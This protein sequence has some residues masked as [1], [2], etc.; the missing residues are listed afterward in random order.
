MLVDWIKFV[1]ALLLLLTPIVWFHQRKVRYRPVGREW[2][3]HW[4]QILG[5]GL[6]TIDFV[7]A[8]LGGWL[9]AEALSPLAGATGT[10]RHAPT[11]TQGILQLT[12]VVLQ[13]VLCRERGATHAPFT[14]VAGLLLGSFPLA[15][16][17]LAVLL[18]ITVAAGARMPGTFFPVLSIALLAIG[19]LL[20]GRPMLPS[21]VLGA[22]AAGSPWMWTLLFVRRLV[23]SYRAKRPAA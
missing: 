9:L 16:S 23:Y 5:L 4:R 8:I 1:P 17:G 14:F 7:R 18:A 19:L 10:W 12:A 20:G 3:E 22:I 21:L 15:I 6:H 2:S 13:S 11:L